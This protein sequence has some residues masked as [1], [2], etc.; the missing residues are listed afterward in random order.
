M[1]PISS[2]AELAAIVELG[3]IIHRNATG[4]EEAAILFRK[5]FYEQLGILSLCE[6]ASARFYINQ[7]R[8]DSYGPT[9]NNQFRFWLAVRLAI[10]ALDIHF[11]TNWQVYKV[12]QANGPEVLDLPLWCQAY[13][14]AP[15]VDQTLLQSARLVTFRDVLWWHKS[16]GV[17]FPPTET[18]VAKA[19][20]GNVARSDQLE[21]LYSGSQ[22]RPHPEHFQRALSAVRNCWSAYSHSLPL[23]LRNKLIE[24]QLAIQAR[25]DWDDMLL[26]EYM[27]RYWGQA[28]RFNTS[29]NKF[30]RKDW[31][32]RHGVCVKW[33]LHTT[34]EP[35]CGTIPS[36][37]TFETKPSQIPWRHLI[38]AGKPV[39]ESYDIDAA[40]EF[41]QRHLDP[42]D[43]THSQIKTNEGRIW[44]QDMLSHLPQAEQ[45]TPS[46][47]VFHAGEDVLGT[48][49]MFQRNSF[50]EQ[51]ACF[52]PYECI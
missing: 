9:E 13:G 21:P 50:P 12:S 44:S 46:F 5:Q 36:D 7:Y 51:R 37:P 33:C 49:K 29:R 25:Y 19:F 20:A 16:E 43:V 1:S 34:D 27:D 38:V 23:E 28:R 41:I 24:A 22:V 42:L 26:S 6:T 31:L 4:P 45:L 35:S 2:E 8:L 39:Q 52:S 18:M 14:T 40:R 47:T 48:I 3:Q 11:N 10:L 32:D 30:I 17:L 15:P